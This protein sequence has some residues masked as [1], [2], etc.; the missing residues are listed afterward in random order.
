MEKNETHKDIPLTITFVLT[1]FVN[2]P[3]LWKTWKTKDVSG[4]SIYTIVVRLFI[5][6]AFG[7]YGIMEA[8]IIIII[9]SIE[10]FCCEILLLLF[11]QM[12]T[13]KERTSVEFPLQDVPMG[14]N[15][16]IISKRSFGDNVQM[17]VASVWWEFERVCY[18]II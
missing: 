2:L 7:I 14:P 15:K 4:F 6:I 16:G 10:V 13:K 17:L 5:Q 9:M 11:K 18:E 12:Y 1:L 3:Q 8:D